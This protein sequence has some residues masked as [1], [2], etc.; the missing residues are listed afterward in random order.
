MCR[1]DP[2]LA[3]HGQ[4]SMKRRTKIGWTVVAAFVGLCGFSV[5]YTFRETYGIGVASLSWLPPEAHNITYIGNG[6]IIL[7]EFDIEQQAW[8]RW[9]NGG[10]YT[11]GYDTKEKRGY[12]EYEH[13]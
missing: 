5:W 8:E 1:C 3:E 4:T 7:A 9:P 2:H 6:I 11:L 12:Y 13:H 10:G